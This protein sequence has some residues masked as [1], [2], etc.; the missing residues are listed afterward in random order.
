MAGQTQQPETDASQWEYNT[1]APSGQTCPACKKP[2][3]TLE[4]CRRGSMERQSGAPA[5][6]YRH[7]DCADPLGV[8]KKA[9]K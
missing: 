8:K 2:I 4:R 1:F 6:V 3:K 7:I 5:V 9:A